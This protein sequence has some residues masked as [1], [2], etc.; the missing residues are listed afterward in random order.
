MLVKTELKKIKNDA[1]EYRER[2]LQEQADAT[3]IKGRIDAKY[4]IEQ[5]IYI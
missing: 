2:H 5:L 3:E 1:V 4:A